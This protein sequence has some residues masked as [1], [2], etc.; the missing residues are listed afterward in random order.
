MD[1]HPHPGS[2]YSA[3]PVRYST[4]EI[5]L[6]EEDLSF[7]SFGLHWGHT[8]SYGNMVTDPAAGRNGNSW[9]VKEWPQ[10]VAVDPD[11]AQPNAP[12]TLA[13][14]WL[15]NKT[16]WFDRD[17]ETGRYVVRF[18]VRPKLRY[19]ADGQQWTL[20]EKDGRV[21]K[22]YDFSASVPE[23]L[24]GQFKSITDAAGRETAAVYGADGRMESFVQTAGTAHSG[25]YYAYN[26]SGTNTGLLAQ[27]T[28]KVN[29]RPVRRAKYSYYG[30]GGSHGSAGDL[31]RVTVQKFIGEQWVDLTRSYYR[32]YTKDDAVGVKHGLRFVLSPLGYHNMVQQGIT[33][34]TS[35]NEQLA[36]FAQHEFRYD[37]NRAVSEETVNSGTVNYAFQREARGELPRLQ[38]N[39][40]GETVSAAPEGI[41]AEEDF[42][43]WNQ[44]TVE[45]RPDGNRTLAYTNFAG[46]VIL[47]VLILMKGRQ[48][49]AQR[50]CHYYRYDEVG[51][52]VLEALPSAVE[53]YDDT[54]PEL[55]TLKENSGLLRLQAYYGRG[56]EGGAPGR[57]HFQAV[58]KGSA[59]TAVKVKE[60]RYE[61]RTI[62]ENTLYRVS[63]E[64][65]YRS[66]SNGGADPATTSYSFTWQN[67]QVLE[68]TTTW[69][70]VPVEQNGSGVADVLVESYD[71]Y[72]RLA[73]RKN[74]R[75]Y[76]T[77][78]S[79]DPA[80]D[81]LVQ[82]VE[83]VADG[84]PWPVLPGP[85]LNLVT[86][87]TVDDEGRPIQELG[88]AHEI[89]LD[90]TATQIRRAAWTVYLD[91]AYQ[92]WQGA[93]YQKVANGSYTLINPVSLQ[94]YDQAGRLQDQLQAV[95]ATT[96]GPLVATDSFPQT[97]WVRWTRNLYEGFADLTGKQVYFAIPTAGVGE[98]DVNY[99]QSDYGSDIFHRRV[100]DRSPG[101]TITR[102]V[103]HPLDW[104]LQRV[105]RHRRHRRRRHPP[106]RRRGLG[107]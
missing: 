27:V 59:G 5:L 3:D 89:D 64:I 48:E 44:K 46:Q 49:T 12:G 78:F 75:G 15:I 69:P 42:N 7:T 98:R 84:A 50:W 95:R 97:S 88:P 102:Y 73:W 104:V 14:V 63:E 58:Q 1:P 72:N 28:Y 83:D 26:A 38:K 13:L 61:A 8:R 81:A 51:R 4:G 66:A 20:W 70:V 43:V 2:S 107:Q 76:L 92:Q 24:R 55:V 90:G 40:A 93:G 99:N 10:L 47:N 91:E 9:F 106:R 19:D 65:V 103:Y 54:L 80:T 36:G 31:Q 52:T 85:H 29:G 82:Q 77:G 101:G 34:E 68:Q 39:E 17:A 21:T 71:P 32:Y 35:T 62:G 53:S 30:S 6:V 105:D 16:L 37:E 23:A 96:A 22:F 57:L 25:F 56:E 45:D 18:S 41:P 94:I 100:R 33:P 86:D 79:Y 11:P 67:F 60:W 87:Y 74:E